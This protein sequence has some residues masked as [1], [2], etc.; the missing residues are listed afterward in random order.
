MEYGTRWRTIRRRTLFGLGL[1]SLAAG[2]LRLVAA[3]GWACAGEHARPVEWD[4]FLVALAGL[5][6][7]TPLATGGWAAVK[8]LLAFVRE[9]CFRVRLNG[10]A[11]EHVLF[12]RFVLRRC[13]ASGFARVEQH[14]GPPRLVFRGGQ[15]IPLQGLRPADQLVLTS[16][17]R[18]Q[19][20]ERLAACR[21]P[22]PSM[23]VDPAWLRWQGG[24]VRQLAEA[25]AEAEPT[26]RMP[27]LAD[28][29]EDAGCQDEALLSHLRSGGCHADD[30]W[31]L[32]VILAGG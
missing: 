31:A 2:A 3:I 6:I 5:V 7:L 26:D 1:G 30:C 11:V 20:A 29:L 17:L 21:Q 19:L 16:R 9:R 15:T 32:K 28:A 10:D 23:A 22:P 4:P 24:V 18:S 25:I 8:A 12:N 27:I 14:C 13:P